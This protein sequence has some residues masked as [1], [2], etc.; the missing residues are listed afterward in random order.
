MILS[1][2]GA[3]MNTRVP[4]KPMERIIEC[5]TVGAIST[6]CWIYSLPAEGGVSGAEGLR[7]CAVIDPGDEASRIIAAL[8]ELRLYPKYLLL[9]HG[10]FDHL[11]ALPDLAAAF[12]TGAGAAPPLVAIHKEDACYVGAGAFSFHRESMT[13]AA[14]NDLYVRS[15]WKPMPEAD[16]L[17]SEGDAIGPFRVVH[18]PGHT[19]GSAGYLDEEEGVLFSGDTLFCGDYGRTDLPGGD[20][21]R[22]VLSLKRLFAMDG[23][24]SVCPGHG[25][26]TTL[27]AEAR[28]GLVD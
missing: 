7:P 26:A 20:F 14:G 9:T 2:K 17:L 12:Q 16:V 22:L 28:R 24:I 25:P 4:R 6:N 19:Q 3:F 18:L 21:T 8:G 1:V 10:H 11:A 5:L 15:L 27:G 13:A 23:N